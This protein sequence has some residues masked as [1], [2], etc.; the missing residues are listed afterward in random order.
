VIGE[1]SRTPPANID[2]ALV[3]ALAESVAKLHAPA[4][5]GT[6]ATP[7]HLVVTFTPPIGATVTHS[8]E[9]GSPTADGCPAMIAGEPVTAPLAL[10]VAAGAVAA[11]AH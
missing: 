3:D 5:T 11:L 9:L 1:W 10:C 7:H 2:P 6:V 8:I 4:R